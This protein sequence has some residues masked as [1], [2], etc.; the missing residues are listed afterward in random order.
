MFRHALKYGI[1]RVIVFVLI[2]YVIGGAVIGI[3]AIV[4]LFR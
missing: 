2:C 4:H 1:V 3:A